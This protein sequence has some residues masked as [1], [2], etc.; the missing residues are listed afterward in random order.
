MYFE[1]TQSPTLGLR[2]DGLAFRVHG[3]G[4]KWPDVKRTTACLCEASSHPQ[5]RFGFRASD[6]GFQVPSFGSPISGFGFR[7]SG[8]GFRFSAFGSSSLKYN[9]RF[10]GLVVGCS[11]RALSSGFRVSAC[12]SWVSGSGFR[13]PGFGFRVELTQ[14]G[15]QRGHGE[16]RQ[17]RRLTAAAPP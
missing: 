5:K 4:C 7:I 12:G 2:V 8:F 14:R 10:G 1:A 15:L 9:L 6:F 11:L 17:S 13:V 3:L 16:R